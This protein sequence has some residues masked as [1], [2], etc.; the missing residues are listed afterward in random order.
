M[1][2]RD[3]F[4]NGHDST[5]YRVSLRHRIKPGVTTSNG[6]LK[7]TGVAAWATLITNQSLV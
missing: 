2:V 3:T 7:L 4:I 5:R 6:N 1:T